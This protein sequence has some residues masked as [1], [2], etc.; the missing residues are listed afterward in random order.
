MN[1]ISFKQEIN[2]PEILQAAILQLLT[3][4]HEDEIQHIL[5]AMGATAE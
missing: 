4:R 2:N 1:Y 5:L 3:A